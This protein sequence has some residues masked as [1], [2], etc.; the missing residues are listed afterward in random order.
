MV[1][2]IGAR[3]VK[4]GGDR[5]VKVIEIYLLIQHTPFYFYLFE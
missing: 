4:A 5:Q 3:Q 2:A 1:E